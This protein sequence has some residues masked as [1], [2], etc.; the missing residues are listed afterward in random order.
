M[1]DDSSFMEDE[2]NY[3]L[4]SKVKKGKEKYYLSQSISSQ[5]GKNFDKSK[6]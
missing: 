6:V 2:E 3:P 5:D 1:R 4:A